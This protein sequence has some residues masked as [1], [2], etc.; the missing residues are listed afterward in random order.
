MGM[1]YDNSIEKKRQELKERLLAGQEKERQNDYKINEFGEIVRNNANSSSDATINDNSDD[2]DLGDVIHTLGQFAN[3]V[4]ERQAKYN[5]VWNYVK[6]TLYAHIG[7]LVAIVLMPSWV[8]PI[9]YS[10]NWLFYAVIILD[11]LQGIGVYGKWLSL[12]D[13][14][15][16][17]FFE[18]STT[19][20][21]AYAG[22]WLVLFFFL[23]FG[24][25]ISAYHSMG[26]ICCLVCIAFSY[27]SNYQ[28]SKFIR[29]NN[30]I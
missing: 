11:V 24:E 3:A 30:I 17:L 22:I 26:I 25:T 27:F 29:A 6:R 14:N 2:N 16:N 9:Y 19:K 1:V 10:G 12:K 7:A 8:S 18:S 15:E 5:K 28:T 21:K 20:F 23:L 4:S 13:D